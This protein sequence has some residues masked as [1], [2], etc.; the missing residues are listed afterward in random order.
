MT[1][2]PYPNVYLLS[3][4]NLLSTGIFDGA[5]VKYILR[6]R[7]YISPY[8]FEFHAGGRTRHPNSCI[9]LENGKTVYEVFQEL[10]NTPED[11]L[12]D[13]IPIIV[14]SA[15]NQLNFHLWKGH[16]NL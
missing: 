11:M 6:R 12:F 7:K 8:K 2:E 5:P 14:S 9:Y 16:S 13:A 15:V 10:R 3:V 1:G 4:P